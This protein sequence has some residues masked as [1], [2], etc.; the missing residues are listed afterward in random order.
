MNIS[1]KTLSV[2]E[3]DK[4]I[5]ML[6]ACA[7]TSGGAELA[8]RLRPT[9]DI[10]EVLR[11]LDKTTDAKR[12]I[13]SKGMPAFYSVKDITE[14]IDRAE[15]GSV[16]NNIELIDIA[17]VLTCAR[18]LSDYLHEDKLFDS[19]LDENFE[20][21]IVC[22]SLE[23][24]IN[25]SIISEDMIADEASSEL[26]SI[27]RKIKSANNK[28]RE[29]LQKLV[30]SSSY[31]KYLQENIVTMRNGRYVVPVKVEYRGEIKGLVHDT[32][33]SGATI[34]V[35]PTGVVDA[36]NELKV[37]EGKEQKEIERILYELSS[38]CANY[39]GSIRSDY[40]SI[41]ELSFYFGCGQLSVNMNGNAPCVSSKRTLSIIDARHPLI[42]RDRVVPI[43]VDIKD[44]YD[45]MVITGPNT[46]GKTVTLKTIGLFT[47]MVQSGLHIPASELSEISV[48]DNILADIGDEQSIE[49]SLSTFSAHM[50]NIVSILRNVTSKSLVLFD[51]LGAGTDPVEGA[52]LAVSLLEKIR[53]VG[54]FCAATTHYAELKAFAL[55]TDGVVNASCEFDIETLKPTYK[56]IIGTPGKS[57]AF[58]ISGKLGLDEEII[59]R[60]SALINSDNKRFEYVIE[61]LEAARMESEKYREELKASKAEFETYKRESEKRISDDV[62]KAKEARERAEE[63]AR[64]TIEGARAS[65][66]F[67]LDEI[68]KLRK[69]KTADMT[70]EELL[71]AKR[72]MRRSLDESD[73][74]YNSVEEPS[75]DDGYILPR[76]LVKG[77]NVKLRNI[78]KTGILTDI[79]DKDGNCRVKI[80]AVVT[81]TNVKNLKLLDDKEIKKSS[82]EQAKGSVRKSASTTFKPELD[83]RGQLGEDGWYLTDKY[84]DDAIL[85]GIKTV[86]IIHGKGTGA[87]RNYL[88]SWFKGDRRIK[89]F[90]LGRYGEGDGG[91]TVI[92][93]N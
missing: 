67:V 48:F 17:R 22:R 79:P 32:S 64:Q 28:V 6:S 85:A 35:E 78:G 7:P 63:K 16:L 58:A 59:S 43:T 14:Q 42:S 53:E 93:L 12:M 44:R 55:D 68:E 4:I 50:V 87:L 60:A 82:K 72:R 33:A 52:A 88:W 74:K 83:I 92:E 26:A 75:E 73:E 5:E 25:R 66:S 56:L 21:L 47:L 91:V 70:A 90:R 15:K 57:N 20:R 30:N 23:D 18:A 39:S 27:R 69:K 24:K 29:T 3:Y 46:G 65:V 86:H 9:D 54:A 89:S 84:L 1:N 81:K 40:K 36:N 51:E 2:L 19:S 76:A 45:T 61:K 11:R 71:E 80:G 10:E 41:T 31:S 49:Q 62:K 34:F 13:L 37:L 77:D 38:E 8:S